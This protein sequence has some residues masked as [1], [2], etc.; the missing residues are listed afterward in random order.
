MA[1]KLFPV[2]PGLTF[3]KVK[4]PDTGATLIQ[5][6]ASGLEVRLSMRSRA[7]WIFELTYSI[8]RAAQSAPMLG[9]YTNADQIANFGRVINADTLTD[10]EFA[11]LAGFFMER[12][13]AFGEW[14]FDDVNDNT[15]GLYQFGWGDGVSTQFQTTF[16]SAWQ[17]LL[18]ITAAS[19]IYQDQSE[20]IAKALNAFAAMTSATIDAS[21]IIT[22]SSAPYNR[23]PLYFAAPHAT[24]DGSATLY[25][26]EQFGTGDGQTAA[27]QLTRTVGGFAQGYSEPIQNLN[28]SPT[29][30]KNG[31]PVD[32]AKFSVSSLGVVT[33]VDTPA[34]N[35]VLSWAGKFYFRCRFKQDTTQFEQ[36]VSNFYKASKVEAVSL[37]L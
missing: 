35:A 4:Y 3:S 9:R 34:L 37:I 10:N 5:Q 8:L 20:Y 18:P 11:V 7:R 22:F 13:G 14:L 33:F 16:D 25:L 21:G 24:P 30:W 6:S 27:F 23:Q 28:G 1:D 31:V 15:V 36:F 19:V 29:I 26:G 12:Q 32:P 17:G 2:L